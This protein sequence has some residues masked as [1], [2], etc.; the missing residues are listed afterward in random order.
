MGK[1]KERYMDIIEYAEEC[2]GSTLQREEAWKI[3]QSLY[4]DEEEIFEEA[5]NN[6]DSFSEYILTQH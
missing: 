6:W 2:C 1:M 3:F 5:W 4:P